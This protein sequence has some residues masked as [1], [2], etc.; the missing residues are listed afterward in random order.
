MKTVESIIRWWLINDMKKEEQ[1]EE[2]AEKL[3]TGRDLPKGER[4]DV[5]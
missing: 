4:E 3:L 1:N 5:Q 2:P